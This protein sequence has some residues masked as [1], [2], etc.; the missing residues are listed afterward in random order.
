MRM[1]RRPC[2]DDVGAEVDAETQRLESEWTES[3]L[4]AVIRTGGVR[5][6]AEPIDP[7]TKD[8]P[9]AG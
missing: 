4:R 1:D 8:P 9:E 6:G 5:E 2:G 7:G 3:L